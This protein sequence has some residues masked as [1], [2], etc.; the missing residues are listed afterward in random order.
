MSATVAASAANR[1][2]FRRSIGAIGAVSQS[3]YLPLLFDGSLFYIIV[4]STGVRVG[5]PKFTSASVMMCKC[6][7]LRK[8]LLLRVHVSNCHSARTC[9]IIVFQQQHDV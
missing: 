2:D 5:I 9:I 7:S 8:H 1:I 4:A 6:V 3:V